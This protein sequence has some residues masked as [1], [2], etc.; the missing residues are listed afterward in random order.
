MIFPKL[1]SRRQPLKKNN[2][3]EF[4][5]WKGMFNRCYSSGILEY[6]NYRGRGIK[7]CTRWL[8]FENFLNDMGKRPKGKYSIDRVDNNR[9]YEPSNCRWTTPKQQ[10]NN[11]RKPSECRPKKVKYV[12]YPKT[13]KRSQALHPFSKL[14]NFK[15]TERYRKL[16]SLKK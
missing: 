15:Y 2:L 13:K 1:R 14:K 9:D 6:K 11:R 12:F 5:T 8:S 16:Y 10:A 4:I 3:V 7:V